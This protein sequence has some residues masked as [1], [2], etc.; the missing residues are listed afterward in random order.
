M[1]AAATSTAEHAVALGRDGAGG[2]F[3]RLAAYGRELKSAHGRWSWVP[4]PAFGIRI[5]DPDA[6]A[7]RE[8]ALQIL[9]LMAKPPFFITS[10]RTD[11]ASLCRSD[12]GPDEDLLDALRPEVFSSKTGA[13][14]GTEPSMI[15]ES[16]SFCDAGPD[17][18]NFPRR[19]KRIEEVSRA[20]A[21]RGLRQR[22][23]VLI[24][25]RKSS[26]EDLL[27]SLY[28]VVRLSVLCGEG[29]SVEAAPPARAPADPLVRACAAR[30]AKTS[31]PDWLGEFERV[32]LD[33][34]LAAEEL[35]LGRRRPARVAELRAAVK[36][37]RRY[38]DLKAL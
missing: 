34:L 19:F 32:L 5:E 4:P 10:L 18:A 3:R 37:F 31:L 25:G 6:L 13:A 17:R 8:R 27:E 2:F 24:T 26:V 9:A 38:Q 36:R 22:H 14:P 21:R 23:R 35:S 20:L 12:A 28:R 30:L 16:G 29:F 1:N 7:D 11:F 33:T 15:I